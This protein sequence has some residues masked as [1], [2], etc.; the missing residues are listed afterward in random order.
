VT[1]TQGPV[2]SG[3]PSHTATDVGFAVD[4]TATVTGGV[5][6]Y[7]I[8]WRF[9]DGGSA[10]GTSTSHSYATAGQWT[11]TVWGNDS[12]GGSSHQSFSVLVNPLLAVTSFSVSPTNP[13]V[14]SSME[15][16]VLVTGGTGVLSYAYAG[17]PVGCSSHNASTMSCTPNGT[18]VFNVTVTVTDSLGATSAHSVQVTVQAASAKSPATFLGLSGDWGYYL[19]IGVIL[20]VILIIAAVILTRR[21]RSTTETETTTTTTGSPTTAS[22]SEETP[23]SPP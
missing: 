14:G 13:A 7:T 10:S 20:V 6:P 23:K 18:G 11:V 21:S 3:R 9:G 4:F 8:A 2:V 1:V 22:S 12:Q 15:F 16:T 5:A 19:L 17:L